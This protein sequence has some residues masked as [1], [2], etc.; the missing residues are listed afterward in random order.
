MLILSANLA[1][2]FLNYRPRDSPGNPV[3]D[4]VAS[5]YTAE[6]GIKESGFNSGPRIKEYLH[7]AGLPPGNP[8]CAA[9]VCWA[10]GQAGINNPKTGYCPYLFSPAQVIWQ[11][12]SN[13]G[14][15]PIHLPQKGDVFGIYFPEKKRIAHVGFIHN[16]GNKYVITVEGNTNLASG[17]EGDG[18]Y[19]KRRLISSIYK[20]SDFIGTPAH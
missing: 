1:N 9:F 2:G 16:W 7:Y 15:R 20:V 5:V 11:R 10:M 6:I 14:G 8:W 13:L 19:R 18:V 17:R 4:K 3:R 12:N